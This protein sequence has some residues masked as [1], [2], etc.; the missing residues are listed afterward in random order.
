PTEALRQLYEKPRSSVPLSPRSCMK[1]GRSSPEKHVRF[2]EDTQQDQ[3]KSL[4][5][6]VHPTQQLIEKPT[7]I[8]PAASPPSLPPAPHLSIAKCN[9]MTQQILQKI[10]KIFNNKPT[11]LRALAPSKLRKPIG[12]QELR[13]SLRNSATPY[14]IEPSA[15]TSYVTSSAPINATLLVSTYAMGTPKELEEDV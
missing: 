9:A 10:E 7:A 5:I 3:K 4:P 13:T 14:T 8:A 6:A 1:N 11:N 12:M 15:Q 2:A